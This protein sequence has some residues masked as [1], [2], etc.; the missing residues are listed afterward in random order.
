MRMESSLKWASGYTRTIGTTPT[1]AEN[2]PC[3]NKPLLLRTVGA[4]SCNLYFVLWIHLVVGPV[5]RKWYFGDNLTIHFVYLLV[6]VPSTVVQSLHT[7]FYV[8]WSSWFARLE[9]LNS[10]WIPR[11]FSLHCSCYS[12]IMSDTLSLPSI[13]L[14]LFFW[15]VS[16][17]CLFARHSEF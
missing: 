5:R 13:A 4:K 3:A 12:I 14:V 10:S 17:H 1:V 6:L 8:L 2:V 11:H 16:I 7:L 9:L 15:L